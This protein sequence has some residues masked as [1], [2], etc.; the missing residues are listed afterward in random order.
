MGTPNSP[1]SF[2]VH[3]LMYGEDSTV[4]DLEC[5]AKA[6]EIVSELVQ[7]LKPILGH[8]AVPIEWIYAAHGERCPQLPPNHFTKERSVR[9]LR[10]QVH[11]AINGTD[12]D[13]ELCL[14]EKG[15]FLVLRICP[16]RRFHLHCTEDSGQP[17]WEFFFF[18][19]V[20]SAFRNALARAEKRR[21]TSLIA[22][23]KRRELLDEMLT[24]IKRAETA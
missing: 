5:A 7:R 12:L 22:I 13:E 3:D 15:T 18:D 14:G 9:L 10:Q 11:D 17:T 6:R 4:R 16:A 21:E 23:R 2:R 20:V 19:E 1:T 24:V 8:I